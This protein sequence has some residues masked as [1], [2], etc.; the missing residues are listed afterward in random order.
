MEHIIKPR[1]KSTHTYGQLIYDKEG[2]NIQQGKDSLFNQWC[3]GTLD[4][5][6]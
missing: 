5:Y 4:S 2:K 6:I 1:Y 3:L